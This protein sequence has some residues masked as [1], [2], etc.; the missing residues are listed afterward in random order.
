[1]GIYSDNG[2]NPGTLL[3]ATAAFTPV[4]GWNTQNVQTPNLLPA[5]TYWL[6][7]LPQ[8]NTMHYRIGS[9][10]SARGASYAFGAMP[11]SYPNSP[12]TDTVHWSLYATLTR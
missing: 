5:G 9:T 8:S 3:A 1:L 2:G 12:L 6:A 11:A 7:Y 10:G 4:A